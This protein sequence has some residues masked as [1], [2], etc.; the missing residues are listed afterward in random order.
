MACFWDKVFSRKD[1]NAV[2]FLF[3]IYFTAILRNPF[4]LP[5]FCFFFVHPPLHKEINLK[6]NLYFGSIYWFTKCRKS[7]ACSGTI[8]KKMLQLHLEFWE[9][10]MTLLMWPWPARM[11]NSSQHTRWFLQAQVHSSKIYW[12]G[13]NMLIHWYIY[14]RYEVRGPSGHNGLPLLGHSCKIGNTRRVGTVKNQNPQL[15]KIMQFWL[16]CTCL[17]CFW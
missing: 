16:S 5:G 10:T 3:C 6:T 9:K 2:M 13:R 14:E 7:Y 15:L 12:E 17:H 1:K 8:S 4:P 11:V